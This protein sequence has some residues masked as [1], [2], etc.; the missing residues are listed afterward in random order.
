MLPVKQ[1]IQSSLLALYD[2][3]FVCLLWK[4]KDMLLLSLTRRSDPLK[5]ACGFVR[6]PGNTQRW[7]FSAS[8]VN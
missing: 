7:R 4:I 3:L 1:L 2:G 6:N 5:E 8:V